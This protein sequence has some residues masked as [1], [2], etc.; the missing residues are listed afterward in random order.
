MTNYSELSRCRLCFSDN[1]LTDA[2]FPPTGEPNQ[3]FMNMIYACTSIKICYE[4]DFPCPVCSSCVR[5]VN[6]FYGYRKKC[7][8]NDRQLQASR[9]VKFGFDDD[10]NRS[11]EYDNGDTDPLSSSS[12]NRY[13]GTIQKEIQNYLK[14]EIK[15]LERKAMARVQKAMKENN[16]GS[17]QTVALN[18]SR[19]TVPTVLN[20]SRTSV[21]EPIEYIVVDNCPDIKNHVIPNPSDDTTDGIDWKEKYSV[22]QMN[23]E[24]LQKAYREQKMKLKSTEEVLK[25]CKATRPVPNISEATSSN[26]RSSENGDGSLG[27]KLHAALPNITVELLECIN[28][29]S[30]VGERGD[31]T[32]VA[33]LAVAVFGEETLAYSSVTGRKSNAHRNLPPKAALC[34]QKLAAIGLKLF[35]RVHLE[36]GNSNQ[37]ELL[38]RTNERLVRLIV[39]QKSTNLRKRVFPRSH[40]STVTL[41][42]PYDA[43]R[44]IADAGNNDSDDQHNEDDE[45]EDYYGEPELTT[46]T[47]KRRRYAQDSDDTC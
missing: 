16:S 20:D 19:S 36:L 44:D 39:C 22:L 38:A 23:N 2:I 31:R 27:F 46:S 35:E 40:E 17:Q 29:K 15:E 18:D 47:I 25:I 32:F 14:R 1:N 13:Y 3:E 21:A 28:Y 12:N 45:E 7:L 43:A 8:D 11:A 33:K 41:T 6:Q 42:G 37:E 34:P 9:A 4:K 30:G 26:S 10:D 24:L 5:I